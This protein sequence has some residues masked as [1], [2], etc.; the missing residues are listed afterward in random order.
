MKPFLVTVLLG[1]VS[2]AFAADSD[3]DAKPGMKETLK[4]L[5]IEDAKRQVSQSAASNP[6]QHSPA[7]KNAPAPVPNAAA[8]A[9]KTADATKPPEEP[10]T[11]LPGI[12][13]RK[14]RITELDLQLHAKD[15]EIAR[16]AQHTKSTD[17][18]QA[19]NNPKL[20]NALS[21][22]GGKSTEYRESISKERVKMLEEERDLLE[23]IARA[24]TPEE[25]KELQ[26]QL[27]ELKAMRR[28]L[29]QAIR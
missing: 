11:K 13:V 25:K 27:D 17:L 28:D 14:S 20:A 9:D 18:D 4:S 6:A 24:K 22:F 5:L 10:P 26:A 21:L 23:E 29:E 8:P 1:L 2:C 19:L 16:E 3:T 7:A 15:K 12:E